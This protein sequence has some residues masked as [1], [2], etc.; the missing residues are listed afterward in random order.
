[1][2]FFLWGLLSLG[3]A[4]ALVFSSQLEFLVPAVAA[5]VVLAL[6]FIPGLEQ[7]YLVQTLVWLLLSAGGLVVFRNQLRRLKTPRTQQVEDPVAGKRAVVIEAIG[8]EPG[9]VR[10]Q[11]T[12]WKAV[13][14]QPL[15]TGV[16]VV[17][18][19]Q[20]GLVLQV[21]QPEQDRVEAELKA[22]EGGGTPWK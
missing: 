20:D 9:R 18:L 10:F 2:A 22:L 1:M 3:L 7:N 6:S 12:T 21:E 8:E 5:I 11:G 15:A 16:E 14:A 17:I 4:G 13:A 19:G